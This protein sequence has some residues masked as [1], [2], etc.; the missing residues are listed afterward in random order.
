[1]DTKYNAY[2]VRTD[3]K[4][5]GYEVRTDTKYT[6]YEVWTEDTNYTEFKRRIWYKDGY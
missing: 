2:E 6:G 5:T 1:M 4:Y 3:T